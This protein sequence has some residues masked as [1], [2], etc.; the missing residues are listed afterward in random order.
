MLSKR[1]GKLCE[2]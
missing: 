2:H 1:A